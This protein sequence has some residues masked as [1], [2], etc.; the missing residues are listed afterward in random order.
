[1]DVNYRCKRCS[2]HLDVTIEDN[3]TVSIP[4]Y[5]VECAKYIEMLAYVHQE[6]I[7]I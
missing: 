6:T 3:I 5:C 2:D 4:I 7:G 1:M